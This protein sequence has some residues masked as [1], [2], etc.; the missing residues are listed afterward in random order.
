[1]LNGESAR[2]APAIPAAWRMASSSPVPTTASTSGMS[3]RIWSRKR[4]TRHPATT[5]LWARPEVLCRAM[6]R[7]V[8]T[9]SCWALAMKEQVLTT[10]T[11]ASSARVVNSA[12]A[13][14]SRPIMTSVSTRFF[15]QPRLT[16]PIFGDDVEGFD[17]EPSIAVSAGTVGVRLLIQS[18]DSNTQTTGR[19]AW[20]ERPVWPTSSGNPDRYEHGS[21]PDRVIPLCA[22]SCILTC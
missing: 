13:C 7:I 21:A 4:S 1:M 6:S 16:N 22:L 8:L 17:A 19:Q 10:M 15:G 11:S 20:T 2:G 14:C 12:P 3:R 5:S 18:F 9:D